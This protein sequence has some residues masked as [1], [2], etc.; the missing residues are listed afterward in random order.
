MLFRSDVVRRAGCEPA[1]LDRLLA[2]SDVVTLHCPSTP[3]TRRMIDARTLEAMKPGA[4]LVNVARGDLV[5]TAALTSS[6]QSGR[7]AGAALD[8]FD[9]EPLPADHPLRSMENVIVSSHIASASVK[10][11]RQ[12]RETV[13]GLAVG[14]LQG[15]PAVNVVNGVGR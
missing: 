9:P 2:D 7:L 10:A 8:V 5:E 14:V 6:L 11:V 13:A 1:A 3:A 15:R 12:L 4:L